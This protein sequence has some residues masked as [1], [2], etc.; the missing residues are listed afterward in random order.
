VTRATLQLAKLTRPRIRSAVGRPRLSARLDVTGDQA[1]IWISGRPG[2]GKTTLVAHWLQETGTPGL[3]YE[4]DA[5]D[6]DPA[7]FFHYLTIAATSLSRRRHPALPRFLPEYSGDLDAFARRFLRLLFDRMPAGSSI[8][9]DNLQEVPDGSPLHAIIVQAASQ[10]PT[11]VS[12]VVIAHRQP[13]PE[14]AQ[15]VV[16]GRLAVVDASAM[17]LTLEEAQAI[18]ATKQVSDAGVVARLHKRSNGW[19]AGFA[20]MADA[21]GASTPVDS[22]PEVPP[23]LFDYLSA[24]VLDRLDDRS[25]NGLLRAALLPEIDTDGFASL[26]DGTAVRRTLEDLHRR[27]LFVE[28]L[29]RRRPARYRLHPL[30]RE[31][32]LDRLERTTTTE[33]LR[34]LRA[35]AARNLE[36]SGD[37]ENAFDRYALAEAWRDA[38][39]VLVSATP[40]MLARGRWKSF[41]A[42]FERLPAAVRADSAELVLCQGLTRLSLDPAAAETHFQRSFALHSRTGSAS[43]QL[44]AAAGACIAIFYSAEHFERLDAW[45][46]AMAPL[47]DET[48]R[49]LLSA[50]DG[51]HV[52]TGAVIAVTRRPGHR[53]RPLCVAELTERV[54]QPSDVNARVSAAAALMLY[55]CYMGDIHAARRLETMVEP[56]LTHAD[57]APLN[58]AFWHVYLSYLSVVENTPARGHAALQRAEAIAHEEGFGFVLTLAYSLRSA[59]LRVGDEAEAWLAKVEPAMHAA[60]AYDI[61]HFLGN[62]QYRAV[63][64]GQWAASV[65]YGQ[66]TV[67]YTRVTGSVFQ[68]LIWE[69][70]LAW[71][72]AELGRHAEA[73]AHVASVS[74]LVESTGAVCYRPLVLLT[75]ARIAELSG[76]RTT[77]LRRLRDAFAAARIDYGAQRLMFWMPYISAARICADALAHDIDPP[78]VR[79]LVDGYPLTAPVPAPPAWPWTIEIRMLGR[80]GVRVSGRTIEF[81]HKTPY[82]PLALLK[83]IVALG[84]TNVPREQL[85]DALWPDDDGD[86]AVRN[87]DV[88]IHRLRKILQEPNV[89]VVESGRVSLDPRRVRVDVQTFLELAMSVDAARDRGTPLDA[90]DEAERAL[91]E[92]SG[93]FLPTDSGEPWAIPM[94]ERIQGRHAEIVEAIAS[95]FATRSQ[96]QDALRWYRRGVEADPLVESFHQGLMRCHIGLGNYI[97]GM[98]AFTRLR[99]ILE[100]S[101]RVSPSPRT[102]ALYRELKARVGIR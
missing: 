73:R 70:P 55:H 74:A 9:L 52:Y 69:Q 95:A 6:D 24:Q 99:A 79:M 31:F 65:T 61:A 23:V 8:V 67:E 97:E 82:R 26:V 102:E 3:W 37:L 28:Q 32:L 100:A 14:Y 91:S 42:A 47:I 1:A 51:M 87:F 41:D 58:D 40:S 4:V 13:G 94:R 71:A 63:M 19:A 21:V 88:A 62:R 39:R 30:L 49:P 46:D 50:A 59:L 16:N 64:R 2:A 98:T 15:L 75:E 44:V 83:A 45:F 43:G 29:G 78:L 90:V 77:Y 11:D 60:R 101:L 22:M 76:D 25:R 36:A 93:G 84:S 20:M 85:I 35:C 34:D 72:L 92:F 80:F 57:L 10:R 5:A 89:V 81:N 68:R 86:A 56:L 7:T 18:A 53:L 17:D 48:P 33:A 66:Q 12:L 27:N 96:W 38:V 54:A